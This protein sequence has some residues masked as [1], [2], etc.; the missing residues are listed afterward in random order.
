MRWIDS[1]YFSTGRRHI[2]DVEGKK[3]IKNRI[4]RENTTTQKVLHK[5]IH[6][7]DHSFIDYI[8]IDY[9]YGAT[10]EAA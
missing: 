8:E 3:W 4:D 7:F 5:Q 10:I 1:N 6:E 9:I 2:L